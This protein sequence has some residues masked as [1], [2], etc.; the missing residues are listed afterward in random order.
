MAKKRKAS[1]IEG[2]ED[3]VI[4][5]EPKMGLDKNKAVT[6]KPGNPFVMSF[7]GARDVLRAG[8]LDGRAV[9]L[10]GVLQKKKKAKDSKKYDVSIELVDDDLFGSVSE[11]EEL[12]IEDDDSGNGGIPGLTA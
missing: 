10:A 6:V 3:V 9:S 7:A 2:H 11:D 4:N 12:T 8:T 1:E 5:I